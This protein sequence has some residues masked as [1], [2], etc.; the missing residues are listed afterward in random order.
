[1]SEALV[2]LLIILIAGAVIDDYQRRAP[3]QRARQR[4]SMDELRRRVADDHKARQRA[5]VA[6]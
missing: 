1:M 2:L 5:K 3:H 6:K 4:V